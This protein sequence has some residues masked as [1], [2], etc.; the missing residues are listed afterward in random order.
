MTAHRNTVKTTI[1]FLQEFIIRRF[2]F[3][4]K[5]GQLADIYNYIQIDELFATSGQPNEEQFHLIKSAGFK[6][7]INLAPTSILENSVVEEEKVLEELGIEYIHIP[8][9]FKN[10]TE[11]KFKRF[12]EAL[13]GKQT[14][15]VWVHC[16]ANMRVSAF[17]Y[18]YRR[19]IL[20]V[21][22]PVA[23][24]DLYKIWEPLGVWKRFV[25]H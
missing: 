11:R 5:Q 25:N 2:P 4:R 22:E 8:V 15:R 16:A 20:S 23:R 19:D 17:T 6:T 14:D 3:L 9:D 13:E 1:G 10:P 7:V 18:R 21:D 12:I 24:Q